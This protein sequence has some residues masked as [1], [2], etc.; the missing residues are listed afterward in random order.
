MA[1]VPSSWLHD[2]FKSAKEDFKKRLKNPALY[3]FSKISS[4]DDVMD[5][6][7]KIERQQAK[8]KTL[9]GL[10]RIQPFIDGL[11]EYA[12]VIEVFAQAKPDVMSLIW[13]SSS[14][15][16]A[17][18]KVI[19]VIADLGMTLPSFKE[20]AKLFQSNYEIRRALWLFYE[21]ILD[22][23]AI[24]VNFLANRRLNVFLES[25]WPNIR[26]SIGKVQEN[27]EQHKTIMT[28][29]VT[30]EDIVQAHQARKRALEEYERAQEF[31]D[32]Q[33]YGLI[34]NELDPYDHDAKL[35]IILDESSVK[36][37]KWL[38][39]EPD[40]LRWRNSTNRTVRRLW[41]HG[42]PGSGKTFLVASLIKR[43][44]DSGQRVLLAFLSHDRQPDGVIVKIF[45][46]LL[47]QIID[48]DPTL[49]H[50]LHEA[51]QS[52][53]RKIRSDSNFIMGLLCKALDGLG[54][55]F[56]IID[57]LDELDEISWNNLLLNVLKINERCKETK[58]LI[59]S[60]EERNIS[61]HFGSKATPLRVDYKN[62]ED[63]CSF[64]ELEGEDL[65]SEMRHYGADERT[66]LKAKDGLKAI[67]EKAEGKIAFDNISFNANKWQACSSTLKSLPDGLDS[68]YGRILDRIQV[69]LLPYL[70]TTVRTIL[71]WVAC[72]QRP[73][74]EEEMLQILA[75]ELG[76]PDFTKE[77]K[78]FRDVCK[79][80]GPII[81]INEGIIQFVHF[82]AKEYLLHDQSKNYLNLF[83][84]HR[85]AALVCTTYLAFSSVQIPTSRIQ[86]RTLDG[87]YVLFEYASATFLEHLKASL[88]YQGQDIDPRLL[89]ALELLQE[90]RAKEPI[91]VPRVPNQF[92]YTYKAFAHKPRLQGFLSLIAYSD[93][94]VRLGLPS[95]EEPLQPQKEDPISLLFDRHEIRRNLEDMLCQRSDHTPNCD[96]EHLKRLYGMGLYYCEQPFCHAYR[97]GFKSGPKRDEHLKIHKRA[98]KC[99]VANCLFSDIGFRDETELQRHVQGAHPSQTMGEN[100]PG[101][102]GSSIKPND[103]CRILEHAVLLDQPEVIREILD[104]DIDLDM[105]ARRDIA[106]L[107]SWK[108]SPTVLS[109]LLNAKHGYKVD[110]RLI[111]ADALEA[112]NL[113]N[114]KLLL[115]LGANIHTSGYS[116]ADIPHEILRKNKKTMHET[117]GYIRALSR[118]SPDL[119]DYLVNECHVEMPAICKNAGDVFFYPAINKATDDEARQRFNGIKKY[120]IWPEAYIEGIARA[121]VSGCAIGVAICLENG[122]N[123]NAAPQSGTTFNPSVLYWAVQLANFDGARIVKSLLQYGADP[124]NTLSSRKNVKDLAGM[125]K[126]EKC[127]GL[128]WKE[129]VSR[130]QAGEDLVITPLRGKLKT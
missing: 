64:V 11:K 110:L 14:V 111:L 123:P 30:L 12:G 63:I 33:I 102:E 9:R 100:D 80:C 17:F 91:D 39:N 16:S 129:I 42:I 21:D 4:I 116:L 105:F 117:P 8:S 19:K 58:L 18:E 57:G 120:I 75:I 99:S 101:F 73:L 54:P 72:A 97:N 61:L 109:C 1:T 22:F 114:I 28:M 59:S 98:Y 104:Q 127:F 85:D 52:N 32:N 78:Q 68:A 128:E 89:V 113:P 49:W 3:D 124:E 122:G 10:K 82:T 35:N 23:Y 92:A 87:D 118:W 81:E 29:N 47:F 34:R 40:F 41:L 53:R 46:S 6:A 66:C 107:A 67:T 106:K 95:S 94:K 2:A 60:R 44:Q 56:I 7:T 50:I 13:A 126:I 77:R 45:Q 36:S 83:E 115:S 71:Q 37:G 108:A 15:I 84:A 55:C 20:Y 88:D 48:E 74:R 121:T 76:Q 38:E 70:R 51:F 96:C 125:R 24:L 25:L 90:V 62:S 69:K 43:M 27:I 119:M 112:E 130:I 86:Q 5:E 65:L 93:M 31:R 79:D 26:S 103:V